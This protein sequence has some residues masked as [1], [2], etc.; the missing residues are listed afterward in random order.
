MPVN[1]VYRSQVAT[2]LGHKLND[3]LFW[4]LTLQALWATYQSIK[5]ILVQIP[6]SEQKL[7]ADTITQ[8]EVNL[9]INDAILVVISS[10]ISIFLASWFAK[11]RSQRA[12][13][14]QTAVGLAAIILN[15]LLWNY[16]QDQ[17]SLMLVRPLVEPLL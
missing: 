13:I 9:L 1:D 14:I 12:Q 2:K 6:A 3:Y 11:A 7:L 10:I 17:N 8:Q 4:G 5:I 15:V 16:L